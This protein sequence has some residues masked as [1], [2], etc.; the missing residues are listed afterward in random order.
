MQ[1]QWTKKRKKLLAIKAADALGEGEFAELVEAEDGF[2]VIQV[3]S[4]LD[5]EATDAKKTEILQAE[6]DEFYTKVY[7]AWR[8]EAEVEIKDKVLDKISFQ[9]LEIIIP[10]EG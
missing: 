8:E 1:K 2:Y 4:L 5:R 7:D 3:T 6:K 10:A 9:R